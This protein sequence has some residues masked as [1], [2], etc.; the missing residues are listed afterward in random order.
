M[1]KISSIWKYKVTYFRVSGNAK[2]ILFEKSIGKMVDLLLLTDKKLCLFL[3][4]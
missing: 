1:V 2:V 3:T 4:A